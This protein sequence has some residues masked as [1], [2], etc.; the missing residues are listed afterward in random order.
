MNV[1]KADLSLVLG[2]LGALSALGVE[3]A[4]ALGLIGAFLMGRATR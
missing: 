4:F 3:S 2:L 1:S